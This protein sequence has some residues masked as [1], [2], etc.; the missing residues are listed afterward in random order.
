MTKKVSIALKGQN[1][2]AQPKRSATLGNKY[3]QDTQPCKGEINQPPMCLHPG[4][5]G[6]S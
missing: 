4:L 6:A 2:S 3:Q 5:F 1:I